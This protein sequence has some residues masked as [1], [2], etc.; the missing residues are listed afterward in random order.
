MIEH[1]TD[2]HHVNFV[3]YCPSE[4]TKLGIDAKTSTLAVVRADNSVEIWNCNH[5]PV[6]L[7]ILKDIKTGRVECVVWC[8]GRLFAGNLDGSIKELP[9]SC[10]PTSPWRR[11]PISV[12]GGACWSLAVNK[13]QTIIAAS[14]DGGHISLFAVLEDDLQFESIIEK[15][16]S[17]VVSLAWHEDGNYIAAACGNAVYIRSLQPKKLR[18]IIVLPDTQVVPAQVWCVTVLPDLTIVAGDSTG[19]VSFWCGRTCTQI[20]SVRSHEGPVLALA[21]NPASTIVYAAGVDPKIQSYA[22]KSSAQQ[23]HA[24]HLLEN[25]THDVASLVVGPNG[26][27]Y[28]GGVDTQLGVSWYPPKTVFQLSSRPPDDHVSVAGDSVLLVSPGE[29]VNWW[30][31]GAASPTNTTGVQPLK[32]DRVLVARIETRGDAVSCAL[33]PTATCAA[34][35]TSAH[36]VAVW[37]LI[38]PQG[39][40][41]AS[42]QRLR[43]ETKGA[44]PAV[45]KVAWLGDTALATV[46][47]DDSVQ[48]W[49]VTEAAVNLRCCVRLPRH[50]TSQREGD[51][52]CEGSVLH[53]SAADDGNWLAL[54][55]VHRCFVLHVQSGSITEM[56][57]HRAAI[58]SICVATEAPAKH[59]RAASGR[60]V[61]AYADL[62]L[63]EYN[64][65]DGTITTFGEKLSSVL[66]NIQSDLPV[67]NIS[68]CPAREMLCLGDCSKIIFI[69]RKVLL[70]YD[71]SSLQLSNMP[72]YQ[73]Y[74]ELKSRLE[75]NVNLSASDYRKQEVMLERR[76]EKLE[77]IQDEMRLQTWQNLTSTITRPDDV[78]LAA[79]LVSSHQLVA[80][81]LK[82]DEFLEHLPGP[83]RKYKQSFL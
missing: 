18:R 70:E 75:K 42:L 73:E 30:R 21:V 82:K 66:T 13:E 17:R 15:L 47:L 46:A 29:G 25:H 63:A 34:C 65:H 64:L 44:A 58:S 43:V 26:R 6:L 52:G 1:S 62:S 59:R 5:R 16:P 35:I 31:L 77:I 2:I 71:W 23:W 54:A 19:A 55:T 12:P 51:E 49:D 78:L 8:Q 20:S 57:P 27:I 11:K 48:I 67:T 41:Q 24:S 28:S 10:P 9:V 79:K 3:N 56:P 32:Q 38:A 53:L 14:S 40:Q 60:V 39:A 37:R 36:R 33:S 61:V 80:V 76:L 81:Q 83:L 4:I 22:Y 68:W 69:N 45:L 74:H 50:A 7:K 72:G